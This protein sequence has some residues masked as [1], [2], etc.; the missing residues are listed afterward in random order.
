MMPVLRKLLPKRI[1][2][3]IAILIIA[4]IASVHVILTAMFLLRARE[5]RPPVHP[6]QIE[7]VA[8]LLDVTAAADR[9]RVFAA[10]ANDYP[11]LALKLDRA[12]ADDWTTHP[13]Q[14]DLGWF[15][16]SLPP[17]LLVRRDPEGGEGNH[18]I[19]VRLRD[20]DVVTARIPAPPRGWRVF[21]PIV[22]TVLSIA[23]VTIMLGIWAARAVTAPLRSFARAAESFSPEGEIS[24]LPEQGPEEVRAATRA[25]N[26]MRERIKGLVEDRTRMLAAVGHDLR[27]PITRLRLAGEFVGDPQLRHQMLRDLDQ[28]NTMVESILI[29]LR[30][31]RSSKNAISLDAAAILQTVCDEFADAGNDVRLAASEHAAVMAQPDELRRAL[32]NV[33]DNAVRYAGSATVSL[34]RAPGGVVI[35][36]DD[37]GPGIPDDRKDAM[38]QPFVRGEPAR[39]MD[40]NTGFGLGL[41]IASAIIA[42]HGGSLTLHDRQPCGLAVRV[43]LPIGIAAE[44]A[45]PAPAA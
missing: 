34:A 9:E 13:T 19:A 7:M 10:I 25:L 17:G 11:D 27:T 3:Q 4:S 16:R 12:K 21:Y 45:A 26:A 15:G 35:M 18:R 22:I 14:P 42:A 43:R 2:G 44:M 24:P 33:I 1:S 8:A 39:H 40:G 23:I 41:S 31:G 6:G 29:F 20:G 32:A 28:M 36:V 30:G 37:E 38:L 5:V